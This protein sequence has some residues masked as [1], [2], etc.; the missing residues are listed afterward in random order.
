[1]IKEPERDFFIIIT[2]QHQQQHNRTTKHNTDEED[3]E[4]E[5][6]RAEVAFAVCDDDAND[7][8]SPARPSRY[9]TPNTLTLFL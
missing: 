2:A 3:E 8:R 5:G 1:M 7:A 9:H 6:R 4:E